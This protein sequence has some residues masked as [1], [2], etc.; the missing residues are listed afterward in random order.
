LNHIQTTSDHV[1]ED[2]DLF[3]LNIL[4]HVGSDDNQSQSSLSSSILDQITSDGSD[5]IDS[6]PQYD[7]DLYCSS[8]D[9]IHHKQIADH[10]HLLTSL[11][12]NQI[13][14]DEFL[15]DLLAGDYSQTGCTVSTEVSPPQP[16]VKPHVSLQ[17]SSLDFFELIDTV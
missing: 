17:N 11:T 10:Y 3:W 16:A 12:A 4:K 7:P 5:L 2:P 6:K 1:E 8:S 9:R 13:D 15:S 14:F